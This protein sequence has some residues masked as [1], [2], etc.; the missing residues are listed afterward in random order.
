MKGFFQQLE[1]FLDSQQVAIG[2][3]QEK[4][5]SNLHYIYLLEPTIKQDSVSLGWR[6]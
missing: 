1:E 3:V 6:N 4:Q 5:P 2:S